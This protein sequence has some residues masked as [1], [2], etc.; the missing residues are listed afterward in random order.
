MAAAR[1]RQPPAPPKSWWEV[2]AKKLVL[3]AAGIAAFLALADMSRPVLNSHLPSAS[4]TDVEA[5]KTG[6]EGHVDTLKKGLDATLE[7]AKA[8]NLAAQQSVQQGNDYR[9]DRLLNQKIT[10]QDQ[11]AKN[12]NDAT[13]K[14]ALARTEIDIAKLVGEVRPA[15]AP[16][17]TP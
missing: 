7:V 5:V 9:L 12:P 11:I 2:H 3:V 13:A 10:L 1:K 16:A 4:Q 15:V 6:I 8:A 17:P 14:A